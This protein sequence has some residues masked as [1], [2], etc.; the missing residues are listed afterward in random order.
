[1]GKMEENI[2]RTEFLEYLDK[3][4]KGSHIIFDEADSDYSSFE[5]ELI[6][7]ISDMIDNLIGKMSEG[8]GISPEIHVFCVKDEI[9]NAFCFVLFIWLY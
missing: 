7:S 2:Y 5:N 6:H 3:N 4:K 8:R 1:M 9:V